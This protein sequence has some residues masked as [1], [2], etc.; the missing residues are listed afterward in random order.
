[1]SVIDIEQI[2]QS[3]SGDEAIML[4][5]INMGLE[6][7]ENSQNEI[8]SVLEAED[9]DELARIIHKLR[10]VLHFIGLVSLEDKLVSIEKNA[11]ERTNLTK[12]GNKLTEMFDVFETAKNELA[13][14]KSTLKR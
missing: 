7:M 12:I 5:L 10:P 1:M 2:K 8:N 3:T 6:R 11:K 13:E 4:D 9:W 14:I